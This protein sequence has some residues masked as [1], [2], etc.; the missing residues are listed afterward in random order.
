M[1]ST[2]TQTKCNEPRFFDPQSKD[3]DQEL[4]A[5]CRIHWQHTIDKGI[6]GS[7]TPI[8]HDCCVSFSKKGCIKKHSH[9]SLQSAS[10]L[11]IPS[12]RHATSPDTLYH[13]LRDRLAMHERLGKKLYFPSINVAHFH[14]EDDESDNLYDAVKMLNKRND[15]LAEENLGMERQL[16]ASKD[17]NKKLLGSVKSWYNKYQD[18]LAT[19]YDGKTSHAE[20]TPSY[21]EITPKKVLKKDFAD[22]DLLSF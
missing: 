9:P 21:A 18:L 1:I 5:W 15:Q 11:K 3:D 10:V 20:A 16:K 19:A 7:N 8:Y 13:W 17:E 6:K 2:S 12:L 14:S 4:M 22:E